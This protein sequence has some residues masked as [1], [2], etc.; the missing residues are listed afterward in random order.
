MNKLTHAQ[1]KD[2]ELLS[3]KKKETYLEN[4]KG[5]LFDISKV[6]DKG[7]KIKAEFDNLKSINELTKQLVKQL[8]D[9][10]VEK[11]RKFLGEYAD[12]VQVTE[13]ERVGMF[14]YSIGVRDGH[15][16]YVDYP[17]GKEDW[18]DWGEDSNVNIDG[19][20]YQKYQQ[21]DI[22]IAKG[23]YDNENFGDFERMFNNQCIS[24]MFEEALEDYIIY[25]K[26]ID[27]NFLNGIN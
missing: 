18:I 17:Y 26:P 23:G 24:D 5:L 25:N 7:T 3:V 4:N 16:V 13:D 2:I 20:F 1:E 14:T 27:K 22:E 19:N 10:D 9:N 11:V 15:K 12:A 8:F 21:Y 6:I